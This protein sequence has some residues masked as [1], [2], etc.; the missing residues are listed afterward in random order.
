M[1][2]EWQILTRVPQQGDGPAL[3]ITMTH[4]TAHAHTYS[5]GTTL[6]V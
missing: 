2:T 1:S 3:L 6:F 4:S 5:V